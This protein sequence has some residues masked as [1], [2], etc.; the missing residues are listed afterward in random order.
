M[1]GAFLR[2]FLGLYYPEFPINL[3]PTITPLTQEE[4]A[5]FETFLTEKITVLCKKGKEKNLILENC[6]SM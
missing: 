1:K 6:P 4:A 3:V 5:D 2:R